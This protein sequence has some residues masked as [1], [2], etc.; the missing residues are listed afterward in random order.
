MKPIIQ[1]RDK[2]L[3]VSVFVNQTE[4]GKSFTSFTLQRSYKKKGEEEWTRETIHLDK[5]EVLPCAQIL[6]NA[7]SEDVS[8]EALPKLA[9]T[10]RNSYEVL[11]NPLD[12][13]DIPF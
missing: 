7:Y 11:D 6:S 1:K 2:N 3:S 5:K 4:D 8:K 9:Q 10:D 12:N 13:T